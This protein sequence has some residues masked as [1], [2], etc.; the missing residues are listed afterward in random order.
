MHTF[1]IILFILLLNPELKSQSWQWARIEQQTN[2]EGYSICKDPSGNVFLTGTV[3]GPGAIGTTTYNVGLKTFINKYDASSN[4]LWT[5]IFK[6]NSGYVTSIASDNGGNTY[7]T[8]IYS[9]TTTIGNTPCNSVGGSDIFFI[10]LDGAGNLV[11]VRTAGSPYSEYA[12]SIATNSLGES[13]LTG[14]FIHPTL[15]FGTATLTNTGSQSYFVTKY[16]SNGNVM[17]ATSGTGNGYPRA[18]GIA[19]DASLNTYVA[20]TFSNQLVA[21]SNTVNATGA[22][23]VFIAK[24]SPLGNLL[25]LMSSG[26]TG[27]ETAN[28]IDI[29]PSGNIYL[30]GSVNGTVTGIGTTTFNAS[31][32]ADAYLAKFDSN[33][34][35]LW[36]QRIGANGTEIGYNIAS[37]STG[38]FLACSMLS[39]V[40]TIGAQTFTLPA[41][42]ECM[43][44]VNFDSGG[45]VVYATT[46]TGGGDDVMDICLDGC[47]L[48]L[49]GDL[50]TPSV[51]FGST[52]LTHTTNEAVFIARWETSTGSPT[53]NI[54]GNSPICA[55]SAATLQA[56]GANS[57]TWSTGATGSSLTVTP[58]STSVYVV[59]GMSTQLNCPASASTTVNV[60]PVPVLTVNLNHSIIC[61]GSSVTL[62]VIGASQ[63][64]WS[65]GSQS[66]VSVVS[67]QTSTIYT[68]TGT[69]S[70][71]CNATAIASVTVSICEGLAEDHLENTLLHIFPNPSRSNLMVTAPVDT[72]VTVRNGIGQL[73]GCLLLK[74]HEPATFDVSLFAPGIYTIQEEHGPGVKK[75]VVER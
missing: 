1:K 11:W 72:R 31:P 65:S 45:N 56:N 18:N 69:N 6:T 2:G 15:A 66:S 16:D 62:T 25:W 64:S 67:P 61:K 7:V 75:F 70:A 37:Y 9:G 35:F 60:S 14:H 29:D 32:N 5:Y 43:A 27:T 23:D 63:Y 44:L 13:A 52:V 3:I 22:N 57:Y 48:Y 28:G 47:R 20:G 10:K 24:Y 51:A 71:G 40:V 68:V 59:T 73:C 74:A 12:L 30:A 36:T 54:T 58:T 17:W 41:N 8:G 4:L 49:G 39:T 46:L 55:G 53:I 21:G 34:N 50:E 19:L 42:T 26:S 38:A 33:G